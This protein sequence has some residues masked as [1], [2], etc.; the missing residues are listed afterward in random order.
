MRTNVQPNPRRWSPLATSAALVALMASAVVTGCGRNSSPAATGSSTAPHGTATR[1]SATPSAGPGVFGDLGRICE[2]ATADQSG[3]PTTG[4]GLAAG[5][6]RLGT[7]GDPGA[8]AAPGLEQ[9]YFDVAKAFAKW[10]NAAG[11]IHGRKLQIDTYDAKLFNGAEAIVTA[12]TK[13]FMLVG[14]GNA[15]DDVD[16]KPR[17]ACQLGQLPA[18]D[19]S[20]QAGLAGL[21]VQ[22]SSNSPT[23]YVTGGLR[24]L[25]AAYP[26]AKQGIGIGSSK[27]AALGAEGRYAQQA[28][29]KLGITVTT[30]QEK[31]PLVDNFR[32]YME[33]LRQSDAKAY[34]EVAAQDPAPEV[35]AMHDIGWQPDFILWDVQFYD[36]KSVAAAKAVT[37]PPSY[38]PVFSLPFELTAQYPVLRQ[39]HSIM[40][41]AVTAPHYTAFT[42]FAFSAWT[43]WAKSATECGTNLT[44]ECILDKAGRNTNWTSG[45]L[46]PPHSTI[47]GKQVQSDCLLLMRL[48]PNGFVYDKKITKPNNGL[49]N[50]DPKNLTPIQP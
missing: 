29:T 48:T 3:A 49:F 12:C 16:V 19:V 8:A 5:T 38:I 41:A 10:C 22:A 45:G 30:V 24:L 28:Y 15:F 26:A 4:R 35:T 13:D 21:Q 20:P 31:P 42:A 6:I 27:V 34:Q 32:P 44:Q 40:Q 25:L 2:P 18:L 17:L 1:R 43:L 37:F 11:G 14:N 9:E 39:I 7:I 50:C 36:P 33:Q 23:R 47:P 46:Y